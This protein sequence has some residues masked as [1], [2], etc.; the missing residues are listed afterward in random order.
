MDRDA[1]GVDLNAIRSPVL[2]LTVSLALKYSP[3][4]V[5]SDR[6]TAGAL[7]LP[8]GIPTLPVNVGLASVAKPRLVADNVQQ[9]RSRHPLHLRIFNASFDVSPPHKYGGCR[10][11][12]LKLLLYSADRLLLMSAA[13]EPVSL[14]IF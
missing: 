10:A 11:L 3:V 5:S 4:L 9:S 6:R 1:V 7:A 8:A 13:F 14:E 12:P 2:T